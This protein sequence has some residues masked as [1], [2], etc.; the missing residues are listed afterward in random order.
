VL[1]KQSARVDE[2]DEFVRRDKIARFAIQRGFEPDL[3]W[4]VVKER[5]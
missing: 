3:V 2:P 5:Y 4:K 1:E